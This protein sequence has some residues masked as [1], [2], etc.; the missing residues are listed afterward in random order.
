LLEAGL[1]RRVGSVSFEGERDQ[2]I[3]QSGIAEA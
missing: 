1:E 3:Q 2:S